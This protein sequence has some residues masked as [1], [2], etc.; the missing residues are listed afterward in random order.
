[1]GGA[2]DKIF[3][4]QTFN[5]VRGND[6][7]PVLFLTGLPL[8]RE[9]SG[10]FKAREKSGNFGKSQGNL[11][12]LGKSRKFMVGQGNFNISD[13]NFTREHDAKLFDCHRI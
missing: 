2:P 3:I 11:N 4:G 8:V 5:C 9:K 7:M 13:E 12:F 6:K 10:K 1:M